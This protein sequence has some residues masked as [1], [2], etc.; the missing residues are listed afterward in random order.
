[1]VVAADNAFSP[2]PTPASPCRATAGSWFLPRIVGRHKTFELLLMADR[3]GATETQRL[4]VVNQG[5]CRWPN[6]T[7]RWARWSA[8]ILKGPQG[9]L[10]QMKRLLNQ[11]PIDLD[12]Q[13]LLERPKTFCPLFGP[14]GFRQGHQR[15]PGQAQK[16]ASFGATLRRLEAAVA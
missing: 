15:L 9:D 8:R 7:T 4:G 14:A 11:S 12:T 3:F 2:P 16:K 13:L 10:R 5:L 6:W 1:M